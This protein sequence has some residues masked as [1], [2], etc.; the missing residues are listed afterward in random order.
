MSDKT[1]TKTKKP[2]TEK[3]E[4]V[5]RKVRPI[6]DRIADLDKKIM[7]H[8]EII[9]SFGAERE[10]L[11]NQKNAAANKIAEDAALQATLASKTTD[12][13]EAELAEAQEAAARL[14]AIKTALGAK[15]EEAAT[16]AV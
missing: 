13:L 9:A 4:K 14:A 1:N 11:L 3:A 12:E 16:P 7:A 6:D 10:R 15:K 2:H 5:T 8:H